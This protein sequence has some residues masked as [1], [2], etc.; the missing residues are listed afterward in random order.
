[1][2]LGETLR[3]SLISMEIKKRTIK[4]NLFPRKS[5]SSQLPP[6]FFHTS[7]SSQPEF[8]YNINKKSHETWR[9]PQKHPDKH[10][11]QKKNEEKQYYSKKIHFISTFPPFFALPLHL[12]MNSSVTSTRNRM[13]LGDT[14]RN[15]LVSMGIKKKMKKNNTILRKFTSSQLSPGFYPF[16]FISTSSRL[17]LNS[18]TLQQQ[19]E[20]T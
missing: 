6:L 9:N 3:N 2:K 14:L 7:T 13:K 20:I 19:H 1:V 11:N 12:N 17:H 16:N 15:T 8:L 18:I 5:T 10:G 4:N